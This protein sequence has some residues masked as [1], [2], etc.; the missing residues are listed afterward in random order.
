[1]RWAT[2]REPCRSISGRC[3][4]GLM[5]IHG[6]RRPA[7]RRRFDHSTAAQY[8][9]SIAAQR[10]PP[11]CTA[12]RRRAPRRH[13]RLGRGRRERRPGCIAVRNRC[14]DQRLASAAP[15]SVSRCLGSRAATSAWCLK[16]RTSRRRDVSSLKAGPDRRIR[17][18]SSNGWRTEVTPYGVTPTAAPAFRV[19]TGAVMR[20]P[21]EGVRGSISSNVSPP[22]SRRKFE[23]PI[24]RRLG[25]AAPP[26]NRFRR[27][28]R[29]GRA[30]SA[31]G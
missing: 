16:V 28:R 1:M 5:P 30:R 15:S 22:L 21:R 25:S 2:R 7:V 9:P 29:L 19:I 10:Q 13:P 8:S 4:L 17:S 31:A 18:S 12:C 14:A 6:V 3:L 11:S 26:A 23:Y 27:S 20:T 24:T